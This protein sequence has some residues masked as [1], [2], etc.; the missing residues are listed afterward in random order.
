M[1]GTASLV[2]TVVKLGAAVVALR[3]PAGPPVFVMAS[4]GALPAV[5]ALLGQTGN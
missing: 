2:L 3:W 4:G 1:S 5:T